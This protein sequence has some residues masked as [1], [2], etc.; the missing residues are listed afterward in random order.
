MMMTIID[1]DINDDAP[2]Y[3]QGASVLFI[4]PEGGACV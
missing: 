1:I 2:H 4:Q 3:C